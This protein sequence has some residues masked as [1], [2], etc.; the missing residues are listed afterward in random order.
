MVTIAPASSSYSCSQLLHG[1]H[2]G[3]VT[4]LSFSTNGNALITLLSPST[5]NPNN[6]KNP[7]N[8]DNSNHS[9]NSY[10]PKHPN[11]SRTIM[12]IKNPY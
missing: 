11:N 2:H 1:V 6:P 3:S 5:N 8:S 12:L 9:Y 7:K 4:S 10:D